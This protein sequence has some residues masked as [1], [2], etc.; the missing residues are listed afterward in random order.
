MTDTDKI[1][2]RRAYQRQYYQNY[3]K[4][5][6]ALDYVC[7]LE[8]SKK[9]RAEK[10]KRLKGVQTV[11]FLLLVSVCL[12]SFV[13]C[14]NEAKTLYQSDSVLIVREGVI[15]TVYDLEAEQE[16]TFRS[17]RVKR[18]EGVSEPHTA[19]ET[20]TIKI[21]IIPSGLRVY[22]KT[23]GKIF[24]YQRKIAQNK[25]GFNG[26]ETERRTHLDRSVIVWKHSGSREKFRRKPYH[27]LQQ[28]CR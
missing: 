23:A 7:N 17:V 12:L 14:N 21:E 10:L 24:T 4:G 19:I 9:D 3:R 27:D 13:G 25:G 26:I 20:D 22:D 6:K 1:E 5:K 11:A 28:A 2:K 18:S 8:Q 15:T 16:Y